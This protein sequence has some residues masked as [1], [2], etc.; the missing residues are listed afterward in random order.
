MTDNTSEFK[1]F[2]SHS[3]FV[4]EDCARR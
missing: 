3:S 1:L 4:Q 2:M